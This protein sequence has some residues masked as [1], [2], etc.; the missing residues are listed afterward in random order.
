MEEKQLI[1]AIKD[2]NITDVKKFANN[3]TVNMPHY[4]CYL[5]DECL[6]H[7]PDYPLHMAV[8]HNQPTIIKELIKQGADKGLVNKDGKIAYQLAQEYKHTRTIINLLCPDDIKR[9]YIA[10]HLSMAFIMIFFIPVLK[11]YYNIT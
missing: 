3:T 4:H 9:V 2:D 1:T 8:K 10:Q 5:K 6:L 11:C 7:K